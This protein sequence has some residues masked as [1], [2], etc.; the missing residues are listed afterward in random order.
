MV[1]TCKLN[2]SIGKLCKYYCNVLCILLFVEIC[3][4]RLQKRCITDF[5]LHN[6]FILSICLKRHTVHLSL[7][8]VLKT[9]CYGFDIVLCGFS[10]ILYG[11]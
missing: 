10:V 5:M 7:Y 8:V 1:R 9:M 3:C 6:M 4:I 2:L 11:I